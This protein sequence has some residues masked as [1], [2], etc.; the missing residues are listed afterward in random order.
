MEN[1]LP[2]QGLIIYKN[3]GIFEGEFDEKGYQLKGK[4]TFA[5]GEV[6]EGDF[7]D[8][9]QNGKGKL[10][11][12]SGEVYEGDWK[13]GKR[14]GKGKNTFADGRVYEGDWKDD[15]SEG[16]GKL[17]CAN[18]NVY[19]GDWKYG[20]RNGK[21]KFTW[22]DGDMYEG[23]WKDGKRNGKGKQTYAKGAVYEGDWKDDNCDGQGKYTFANGNVYEGDFKNDFMEGEGIMKYANGNVYDGDW[24]ADVHW[25]EGI[26][27]YANGSVYDGEWFNGDRKGEGIMTYANKDVYDGQWSHDEPSGIGHMK[28]SAKEYIGQ[29]SSGKKHGKGRMIIEG[30]EGPL[31]RWNQDV[32]DTSV[33]GQA[34]AIH[35]GAAKIGMKEYNAIIRKH[36]HGKKI[37]TTVQE[38]VA[39]FE[40]FIQAH[41]E[42]FSNDDTILTRLNL[43][44][45]KA[46]NLVLRHAETIAFVFD[47][48]DFFVEQYINFFVQD[49]STYAYGRGQLSCTDGII[50]RMF[51]TIGS[52]AE[53]VCLEYPE[54]CEPVYKELLEVFHKVID[55]QKFSQEWFDHRVTQEIRDMT[56]Q[57]RKREWIKFMTKKYED[58]DIFDFRKEIREAANKMDYAFQ[59]KDLQY[60]GGGRRK[61]ITSRRRRRTYATRGIRFLK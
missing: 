8:G 48:K 41:P 51:M 43:I 22:G 4:N 24:Q 26:M 20:I 32:V 19:E 46:G 53:A 23:E 5:D 21:G 1:N 29:F 9:K 27:K 55:L 33:E 59:D 15:R 28:F 31:Q 6:Y 37:D 54:K 2:K 7:K 40:S 14:N 11:L 10:I 58:H 34:F 3:G 12:V 17:T 18:G 52:V 35:Q 25:G 38:I 49:C 47:Q 61:T 42:H 39:R 36:I 50:E 44:F 56:P 57:Q 16:E 13:D 30:K 45:H 60:G